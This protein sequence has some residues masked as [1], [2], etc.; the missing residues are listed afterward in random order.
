MAIGEKKGSAIPEQQA[1]NS[2]DTIFAIIGGVTAR[3]KYGNIGMPVRLEDIGVPGTRGFGVGIALDPPSNMLEM[4]GTRVKSSA[5]YGNYI[6]SISGSIMVYEPKHYVKITATNAY[7]VKSI[8]DFADEAAAN[9]AGYFLP[10]CF[11]DGGVAING[12][13]RDKYQL[14][15]ENNIAVSKQGLIPITSNGA[16]AGYGFANCTANSQ[17]PTN[18]YGGALAVAKSRGNDFFAT[19][20]FHEFDLM[21]LS[22]AHQQASTG[23]TYCAWNDVS[24]YAP[25]G[26]NNNALKD[27]NDT[28]VVF[29]TAG[30]ADSSQRA[31]TGSGSPFAKTTHNGQDCGISG[32][33][34]N[35][36]RILFGLTSDGTNLYTLKESMLFKNLIDSTIGANAAFDIANFDSLGANPSSFPEIGGTAGWEHLGNSTNQVFSGEINRTLLNYKLANAGL[37]LS[38]GYSVGGTATFG[39]DGVYVPSAFPNNLCALGGGNWLYSTIAGVGAR[40]LDSSRTYSTNSVGAVLCLSN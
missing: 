30:N 5:N 9:A 35:Q 6:D 37:P 7:D 27:V 20:V 31:L 17:T 3:I 1:I 14:G 38:S 23:T 34:G 12:Y 4:Y 25:K 26:N 21:C 32:V 29:T 2:D 13:F 16:I 18:N 15:I 10:R 11:I 24:P 40:Y 39:N 22:I 19:T 8:Y 36:W 33:N 28:S